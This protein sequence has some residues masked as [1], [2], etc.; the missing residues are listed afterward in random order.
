MVRIGQRSARRAI[1]EIDAQRLQLP[2]KFDGLLDVPAA[3]GRVGR[4]NTYEER[5]AFRPHAPHSL[6]NLADD[7]RPVLRRAAVIIC[8]VIAQREQNS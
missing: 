2:R 4:R 7:S 5:I 8:A 1:D 3:V 6:H